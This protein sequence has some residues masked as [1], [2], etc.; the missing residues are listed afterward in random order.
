[1]R[2]RGGAAQGDLGRRGQII[3]VIFTLIFAGGKH[4]A[5]LTRTCSWHGIFRRHSGAWSRA[6]TRLIATRANGKKT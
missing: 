5:F 6:G 2:R 3:N 4:R 1:M